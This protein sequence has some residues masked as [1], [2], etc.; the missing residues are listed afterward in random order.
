MTLFETKLINR[1]SLIY[2]ISTHISPGFKRSA[3][4]GSR[5]LSEAQPR[6][7]CVVDKMLHQL[8]KAQE[9]TH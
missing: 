9:Q 8:L 5:G 6:V 2:I 3:T 4:P 7:N 1:N